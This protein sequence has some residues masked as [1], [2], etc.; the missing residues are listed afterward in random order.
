MNTPTEKG[1]NMPI[2]ATR[3]P[4]AQVVEQLRAGVPDQKPPE[5]P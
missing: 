2:E 1:L 3:V 4:V 5:K